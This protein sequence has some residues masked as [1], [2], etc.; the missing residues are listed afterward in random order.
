MSDVESE[1]D[2]RSV[3]PP[4]GDAPEA[5]PPTAAD[6]QAPVASASAT[7]TASTAAAAPGTPK[8][9]LLD[10]IE[11]MRSESNALRTQRLKVRK[12]LKNAERKRRRLKDKAR[13]LSDEDLRQVMAMR[14][15]M[16]P[17]AAQAASSSAKVGAPQSSATGKAG[18]AL[19]PSS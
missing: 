17:K 11:K 5:S 2:A 10:E 4:A 14:E 1:R 6:E 9:T 15:R 3:S 12:D 8:G 19:G 7:G 13:T 16:P 18:G